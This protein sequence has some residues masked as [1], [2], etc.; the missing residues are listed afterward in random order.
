[1]EPSPPSGPRAIDSGAAQDRRA[2]VR[3]MRPFFQISERP[4]AD[5]GENPDSTGS[6]NDMFDDSLAG[7]LAKTG[8]DPSWFK[9]TGEIFARPLR[10]GPRAADYYA[11]SL[12]GLGQEKQ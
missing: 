6:Y 1:M 4:A 11:G 8:S 3:G 9:L 5:D 7:H 12:G 10:S 2:D